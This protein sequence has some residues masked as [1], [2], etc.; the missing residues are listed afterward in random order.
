M[1][2]CEQPGRIGLPVLPGR[3][4]RTK[5]EVKEVRV[6]FL[7][8]SVCGP[9]VWLWAYGLTVVNLSSA[10]MH[11]EQRSGASMQ[12][13]WNVET[14]SISTSSPDIVSGQSHQ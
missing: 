5:I 12:P 7:M 10:L 9:S 6:G 13:P 8:E 3:S 14:V 4:P 2:F 1:L 11:D